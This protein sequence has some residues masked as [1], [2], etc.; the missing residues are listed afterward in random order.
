MSA[1]YSGSCHCGK[2]AYKVT[3]SLDS[4]I[5]CNCSMCRRKGHLLAFAPADAFTLS[6]GESDL[7]DYQFGSKT[8]HHLFCKHCGVGAF[9]RGKLPN[10]TEMVAINVGCLDGVDLKQLSVQEVD[11]ASV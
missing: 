3:L 7:S 2:V 8:I 1:Q 9:G 11:G 5:S 6:Q 4:V 10:G